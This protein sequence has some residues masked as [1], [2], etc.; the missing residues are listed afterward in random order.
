MFP[1]AMVPIKAIR[2]PQQALST[3]ELGLGSQCGWV[4]VTFVPWDLL[5]LGREEEEK[6][7]RR[8]HAVLLFL[9]LMGERNPS[10]AQSGYPN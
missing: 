3:L 4:T 9:K 10:S 5:S 6:T 7:E 1:V 2:I 8:F